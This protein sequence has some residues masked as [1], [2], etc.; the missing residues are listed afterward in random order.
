MLEY[1]VIGFQIELQYSLKQVM[2]ISTRESC[3]KQFINVYFSLL[4][5]INFIRAMAAALIQLHKLSKIV[6]QNK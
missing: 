2:N 6:V 3:V 1:C 5:T 4:K